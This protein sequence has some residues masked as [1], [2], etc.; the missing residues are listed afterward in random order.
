M[1]EAIEQVLE[2]V[3]QNPPIDGA[4]DRL[5]RMAE[6]DA[7]RS[8]AE[9]IRV[10][11]EDCRPP[12]TLTAGK[13]YRC[14][15]GVVRRCDAAMDG[16][17]PCFRFSDFIFAW[18]G[19]PPIIVFPRAPFTILHEV[20]VGDAAQREEPTLKI[21][22]P[23]PGERWMTEKGGV[24]TL[25]PHDEAAIPIRFTDGS[26]MYYWKSNCEPWN[27]ASGTS[28]RFGRL[29]YRMDTEPATPDPIA[30]VLK[31]LDE[32]HDTAYPDS[33]RLYLH[34]KQIAGL[35]TLVVSL[36]G[37]RTMDQQRAANL[38]REAVQ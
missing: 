2:S 38:F 33:K 30:A 3:Y 12:L 24:V 35:K 8:C 32:V 31:A 25:E 22:N 9:Q 36:M 27:P 5:L 34:P 26:S 14:S 1:L 4:G 11:A 17:Q 28:T 23:L 10:K 19:V 13:W 20:T 6:E 29:L 37:Q 7:K 21:A 16:K 18:D 15:D